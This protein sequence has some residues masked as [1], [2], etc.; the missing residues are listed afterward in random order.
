M[1][2]NMCQKGHPVILIIG[3]GTSTVHWWYR[4]LLLIASQAPVN[5]DNRETCTSGSTHTVSNLRLS[6]ALSQPD[7]DI[8]VHTKKHG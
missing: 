4:F 7:S 2:Y 3:Y 1:N 6:V 8:T 5:G